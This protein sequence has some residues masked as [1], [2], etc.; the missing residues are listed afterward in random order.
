MSDGPLT[1]ESKAAL[2]MY[3]S[4][5]LCNQTENMRPREGKTA[6][7]ENFWDMWKFTFCPKL[8]LV[9]FSFFMVILQVFMWVLTLVFT[10][11]NQDE[12]LNEFVFLG[13]SLKVLDKWGACNPYQI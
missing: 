11:V 8:S 9:S 10:G 4:S 7:D 6:R 2:T 3:T 5:G 12:G 1:E 13:P